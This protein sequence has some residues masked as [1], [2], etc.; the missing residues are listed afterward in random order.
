MDRFVAIVRRL[1]QACGITAAVLLAAA[2]LVVCQMVVMRYFLGASTVWQTEFVIYAIVAST[3]IGAPYVLLHKGHV[4]VDLVPLYVR[5]R[6]RLV[7]ALL[8][9]FASLAFCLIVAIYGGHYLY[10][11]WAGGW[12][13]ETVWAVPLWIPLLALP[14]GMG[15]LSLQYI[16]DILCLVTGR[17]APFGMDP[18]E[19]E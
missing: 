7:L 11:A 2:T 17:D 4:N 16:A 15:L 6:T 3:F 1:S 18:E 12:R 5:H 10:E 9:S 8:G 13:T 19:A 14:L